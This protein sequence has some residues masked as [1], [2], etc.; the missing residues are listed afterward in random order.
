M[1]CSPPGS[2]VHGI[3]QARI[4]EWVALPSSRGSSQP[5]D[6][7]QASRTTSGFFTVWATRK[8][9]KTADTTQKKVYAG[10]QVPSLR[11]G[12]GRDSQRDRKTSVYPDFKTSANLKMLFTQSLSKQIYMCC[13]IWLYTFFQSYISTDLFAMCKAE[14]NTE[15]SK[16]YSLFSCIYKLLYVIIYKQPILNSWRKKTSKGKK[17]SE[18]N[19]LS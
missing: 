7:S 19:S 8:V 4:L 6:R 9:Q 17:T 2:S 13:P 12:L 11:E 3:L 15:I 1:D 18:V 10:L 14:E 16:I 5:R